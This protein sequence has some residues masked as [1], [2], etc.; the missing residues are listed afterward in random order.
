M[1]DNHLDKFIS[2]H[3]RIFRAG[4]SRDLTI[5]PSEEFLNYLELADDHAE[6]KISI[7]EL[8]PELFGYEENIR[9]LFS[10]TDKTLRIPNI[11][12]TAKRGDIYFNIILAHPPNTRTIF[13]FV[14]DTTERM[15]FEW[16]LQQS[17]NEIILLNKGI[18]DRNIELEKNNIELEIL[19]NDLKILNRQL[20]EKVSSRTLELELNLKK[21]QRV[22]EQTVHSLGKALEKRD[23]Y[24]AGH[25]ERVSD[26]S[27]AIARKMGF[28]ADTVEGI[29][30]A[31]RLHD[32]GKIYVPSEFLTRPGRLTEEEFNVIKM[33]PVIGFD[34]LKDIEFPWPV[35][36]IVLQ[37][38]ERFDGSGYPFGLTANEMMTEAQILAVSDTVETIATD[39]PY[40]KT[41][42]LQ[43]A[44]ELILKERGKSLDPGVVDACLD[45]FFK[46]GYELNNPELHID[47]LI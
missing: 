32:I 2:A 5:T 44:L 11:S 23:P 28:D 20:E 46:D 4:I 33:H 24:T 31:S 34:I 14:E 25:Q 38:H 6:K 36:A 27:V 12:R 35:A 41:L 30:I 1:S 19:Q 15:I 13:L 45:I 10:D 43:Y 22:F 42:G 21:T 17:R 40:R 39:R 9:E 26:L 29:K 47:G 18:S 16:E 7:F 37:H 8:L 3:F